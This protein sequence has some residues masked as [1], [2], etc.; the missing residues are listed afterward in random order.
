[1]R[2]HEWHPSDLAELEYITSRIP[3]LVCFM[4]ELNLYWFMIK[5][6]FLSPSVTKVFFQ[7]FIVSQYKDFKRNIRD[8]LGGKWGNKTE[9]TMIGN[10]DCFQENALWCVW[11]RFFITQSIICWQLYPWAAKNFKAEMDEFLNSVWVWWNPAQVFQLCNWV[12]EQN[13]KISA[14]LSI[15]TFYLAFY[16]I[17]K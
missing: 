7:E 16:F 10:N 8:S 4:E 11:S 12:L 15:L 1:M 17:S 6:F 2:R 3:L 5:V 13:R 14:N 9:Y